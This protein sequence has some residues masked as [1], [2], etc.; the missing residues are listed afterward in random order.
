LLYHLGCD[1]LKDNNGSWCYGPRKYISKIIG[2]YKNMFGVKPREYTSPL[3]KG[4]H[5]EI[6]Q[7]EELDIKG[8]KQ[9]QR[10]QEISNNDW[11]SSVGCITRTV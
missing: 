1:Y 10:Y 8:I 11:L 2:Q 7:T 5:P 4:D 9:Y 6:D 3:E